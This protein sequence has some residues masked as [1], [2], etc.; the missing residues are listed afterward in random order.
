MRDVYL[1]QPVV[2]VQEHAGFFTLTF[3]GSFC[4]SK[5]SVRTNL[6]GLYLEGEAGEAM[7][8]HSKELYIAGKCK[9]CSAACGILTDSKIMQTPWP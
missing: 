2:K 4:E 6:V 1:F 8:M 3:S 5:K 7:G 9:K